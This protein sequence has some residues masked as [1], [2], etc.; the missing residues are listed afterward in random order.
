MDTRESGSTAV[1]ALHAII[2]RTYRLCVASGLLR[3]CAHMIIGIRV[4][5]V[6]TP[7]AR[8]DDRLLVSEVE[9]TMRQRT[10]QHWIEVQL[11]LIQMI[12]I[13]RL[14]VASCLI[15]NRRCCKMRKLPAA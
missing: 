10:F 7:S 3:V 13:R 1:R 15:A 9:L 11:H 4:L 8:L 12:H 6:A 5:V 2:D 14:R